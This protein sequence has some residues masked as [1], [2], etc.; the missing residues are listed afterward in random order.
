MDDDERSR[1]LSRLEG[2]GLR[3]AFPRG[4]SLFLAGEAAENFYFLKAGEVRVFR[5][6]SQGREVEVARLRAGDFLG[7]AVALAGVAYP[8]SAQA[9]RDTLTLSFS[10]EPILAL[11]GRDPAVAR[12]LVDLLARKCLVLNE[13][14][15]A[16]GLRTVRLRL[17]QYLLSH[18]SGERG[19]LIELRLKKA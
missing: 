12:F 17:T 11:A 10:R 5:T 14:V 7:E 4:A 19:C 18:C 13:R 3:R 6:D 1:A 9:V 8:A 2:A 15:E 16:L